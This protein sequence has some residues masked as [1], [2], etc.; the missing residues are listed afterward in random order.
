M[1]ANWRDGLR[2]LLADYSSNIYFEGDPLR[3]NGTN[4]KDLEDYI[5]SLL[6][7]QRTEMVEKVGGLKKEV[8]YKSTPTRT[9]EVPE[10]AGF[11]QAIDQVL[12]ILK[13]KYD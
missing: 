4:E 1:K 2:K 13:E 5:E 7:K 10:I 6:S 11:N 8:K 3:S 9:Q 12:S